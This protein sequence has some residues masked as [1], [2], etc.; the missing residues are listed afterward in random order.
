MK[1]VTTGAVMRKMSRRS[2]GFNAGATK[3]QNS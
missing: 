1:S 3:R 2:L